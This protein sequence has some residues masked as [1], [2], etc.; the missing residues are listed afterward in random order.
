MGA[1]NAILSQ[2][3][4]F[5]NLVNLSGKKSYETVGARKPALILLKIANAFHYPNFNKCE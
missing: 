4:S 3:Y 5:T 1:I 2:K